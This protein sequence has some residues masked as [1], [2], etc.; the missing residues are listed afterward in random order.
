MSLIE[1]KGDF[2]QKIAVSACLTFE[3]LKNKIPKR[4]NSTKSFFFMIKV[5]SKV[6]LVPMN[7]TVKQMHDKYKDIDGYL[8]IY[9]KEESTF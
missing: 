3:G 9:V 5:G 2:E 1:L 8:R 6:K 4:E 7:T